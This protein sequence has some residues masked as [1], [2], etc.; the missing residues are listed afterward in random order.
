MR[1][2]FSTMLTA[3]ASG[4]IVPGVIAGLKGMT[5]RVSL[6]HLLLALAIYYSFSF[7]LHP[8]ERTLIS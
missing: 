2:L 6:R 3:A 5:L 7:Y 4:P 8:R 1:E